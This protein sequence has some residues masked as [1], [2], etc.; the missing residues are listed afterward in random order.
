MIGSNLKKQWKLTIAELESARGYIPLNELSIESRD[1]LHE[2]NEFLEQNE[3]ELA[4]DML[5]EIGEN[6]SLPEDFWRCV[7]K[8]AEIMGLESRYTFYLGKIRN[9]RAAANKAN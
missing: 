3:L 2:Y 7:K 9:A 8:A 5:E 6:I 4:L 1:H